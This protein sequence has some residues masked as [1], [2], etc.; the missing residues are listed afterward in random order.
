MAF[1]EFDTNGGGFKFIGL[2]NFIEVFEDFSTEPF[3]H[4]SIINSLELFLWTFIFSALLSVLFSYYIY[5]EHPVSG[6]FKVILYLPHIISS[7]VFVVMYKYFVDVAV[8]KVYEMAFGEEVKGLIA[9]PEI[10]R[11]TII[12]YTIW[13]SFGTNVL[14]YTSTMTSISPS[15]PFLLAMAEPFSMYV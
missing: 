5:K 13:V 11:T 10:R 15:P 9:N 3:L 4:H 7:V 6:V 14:M 2:Q 8:P 12:I 1:Q